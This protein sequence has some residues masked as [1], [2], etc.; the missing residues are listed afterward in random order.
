MQRLL[1]GKVAE[2]RGKRLALKELPLL[3]PC[4]R[5]WRYLGAKRSKLLRSAFPVV[6]SAKMKIMITTTPPRCLSYS[7]KML[8]LMAVDQMRSKLFSR[9]GGSGFRSTLI[10]EEPAETIQQENQIVSMTKR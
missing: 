2:Q 1:E 3:L 6:T 4:G 10:V 9:L 5:R 8:T 7:R